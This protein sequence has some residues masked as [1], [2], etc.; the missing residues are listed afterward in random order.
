MPHKQF[1]MLLGSN[2]DRNGL[3]DDIVEW[4]KVSVQRREEM[5]M[6]S[7]QEWDNAVRNKI[8]LGYLRKNGL[9]ESEIMSKAIEQWEKDN[10]WLEL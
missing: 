5:V 8:L 7:R 3:D 6:V 4:Q 2:P 9:Q 10:E 1:L